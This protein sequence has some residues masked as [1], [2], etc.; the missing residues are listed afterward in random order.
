MSVLPF[1]ERRPIAGMRLVTYETETLS[2]RRVRIEAI[3]DDGAHDDMGRVLSYASV[4]K[5]WD[6]AS[7]RELQH[8]SMSDDDWRDLWERALDDARNAT[9]AMR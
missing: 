8:G 3:Y 4:R 5:V 6:A 9:E 7:G 1:P 2:G